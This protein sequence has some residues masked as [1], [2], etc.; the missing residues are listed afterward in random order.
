MQRL[1]SDL[2]S[3]TD[4][5]GRFEGSLPGDRWRSQ[6]ESDLAAGGYEPPHVRAVLNAG[7]VVLCLVGSWGVALLAVVAQ[8]RAATIKGTTVLNEVGWQPMAKYK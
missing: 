6:R 5:V 2:G 4:S 3:M 8:G 1:V 7:H